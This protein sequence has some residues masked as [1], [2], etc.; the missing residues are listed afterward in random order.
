MLIVAGLVFV[1]VYVVWL[2]QS[3]WYARLSSW[4]C[5]N[6]RLMFRAAGR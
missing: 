4:E 1:G 3:V 6:L 2:C 5:V